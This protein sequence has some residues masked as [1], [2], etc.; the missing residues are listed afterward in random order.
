MHTYIVL[1]HSPNHDS[2]YEHV[3]WVQHM[4]VAEPLLNRSGFAFA[5]ERMVAWHERSC[6][7]GSHKNATYRIKDL[8]YEGKGRAW[9]AYKTVYIDK[10]LYWR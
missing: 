9:R 1:T 4:E 5:A 10:I 6:E 2:S 7:R 8:G 3:T